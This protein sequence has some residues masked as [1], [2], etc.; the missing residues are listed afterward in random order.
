MM[1]QWVF[2]RDQEF[3]SLLAD[4]EALVASGLL[5]DPRIVGT[6]RTDD[7]PAAAG[8]LATEIAG[9]LRHELV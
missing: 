7:A 3:G 1:F 6:E 5:D 4:F 2:S 9:V 8:L